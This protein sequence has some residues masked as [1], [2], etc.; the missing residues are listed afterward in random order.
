MAKS[1]VGKY[2]AEG[3]KGI[4]ATDQAAEDLI[5]QGGQVKASTPCWAW[6]TC[7]SWT[8]RGWR[9]P[10]RP[11]GPEPTDRQLLYPSGG[12]VEEFDKLM[13]SKAETSSRVRND[14]VKHDTF[15][16]ATL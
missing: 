6:P 4:S 12:S 5:K 13:G 16:H 7:L 9:R 3:V 10:C 11:R 15:P 1:D 14:S 8:C 2:S